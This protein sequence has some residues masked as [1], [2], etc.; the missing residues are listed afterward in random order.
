MRRCY[1]SITR[2]RVPEAQSA[3]RGGG[4]SGSAELDPLGK[5]GGKLSKNL[6]GK[7]ERLRWVFKTGKG[8]ADIEGFI[9]IRSV[10]SL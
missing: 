1:S 9:I 8:K 4:R 5:D 10:F 3:C 2:K 7:E 6:E